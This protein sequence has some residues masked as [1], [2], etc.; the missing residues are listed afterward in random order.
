MP[1]SSDEEEPTKA[2]KFVKGPPVP[3]DSA[4]SSI[5]GWSVAASA[6]PSAKEMWKHELLQNKLEKVRLEEREKTEK[7]RMKSKAGLIGPVHS[8]EG[9][10]HCRQEAVEVGCHRRPLH[11]SDPR[12]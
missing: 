1:P 10:T 7:E 8:A 2:P 4:P 12:R 3:T 9:S 5:S 11:R 6:A